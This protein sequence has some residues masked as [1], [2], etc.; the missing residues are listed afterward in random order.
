MID[1][2]S[3]FRLKTIDWAALAIGTLCLVIGYGWLYPRFLQYRDLQTLRDHLQPEWQQAQTVMRQKPTPIVSEPDFNQSLSRVA[4]DHHILITTMTPIGQN[5]WQVE[6]TA[7]YVQFDRFLRALCQQPLTWALTT[8]Q[9]RV[10]AD[11][12]LQWRLTWQHT[13]PPLSQANCQLTTTP[14]S[15]AFQPHTAL[16]DA[17]LQTIPLARLEWLGVMQQ[18]NHRAALIRFADFPPRLIELGD[19]VGQEQ[20]RLIAVDDHQAEWLDKHQQRHTL[21]LDTSLHG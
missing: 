3:I 21:V 11:Q 2:Y 15:Q 13:P 5:Q 10:E 16:S 9:L 8:M 1:T 17:I 18:A 6:G 12:D 7:S 4:I 19:T 20:W 14:L